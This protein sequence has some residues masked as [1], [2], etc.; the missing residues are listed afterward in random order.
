M[1]FFVPGSSGSRVCGVLLPALLLCLAWQP[2]LADGVSLKELEQLSERFVVRKR[3]SLPV[4][5]RGRNKIQKVTYGHKRIGFFKSK[6]W[7]LIGSKYLEISF[8]PPS[9][10]YP[11]MFKAQSSAGRSII[12]GAHKARSPVPNIFRQVKVRLQKG[13][14]AHR[15]YLLNGALPRKSL[16]QNPSSAK[17]SL[18]PEMYRR[19]HHRFTYLMVI[20]RLGEVVWLHVPMVDETLFSSYLSAK[21]VG[22]GYYGL[23]FGKHSG[24]FEIVKY[25]GQVMRDFS[26]KDAAKPFVMHHDFETM[27]SKKLYAVGNEVKDLY[28]FTKKS[29]DRG[30][31]FVTDTLIGI[32][33]LSGRYEK[34]L[35]FNNLFHPGKTPFMTG[36]PID[37]K[38]FVLWGEPKA[39]LDFLHINAV[40][41][42]PGEGV[43]VSFRNIS[44]V[45][46]V[47]YKFSKVLWTLGSDPQDRY[48]IASK[49]HRFQHQ[50]TPF[51]PS[52][53]TMV[54]FD[55]AIS[56]RQSRVVKYRLLPSA[57][58]AQLMWE[59]KPSPPLFSKD[60][61]SVYPIPGQD[62]Y[63]VYFVKPLASHEKV[64][65]IPHR[66][67]YFEVH[68][69][70][71]VVKAKL[72]I[73]FPVA[74]PGYRM[75]P[76]SS[77]SDDPAEGLA[78]KPS[79]PSARLETS[80]TEE[81]RL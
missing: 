53:S 67:I 79:S 62:L 7:K 43:L 56:T 68:S 49:A 77:L 9:Y 27:G 24:Y 37:D 3:I 5:L 13:E 55:N 61:S 63:G 21:K 75:M 80:A 73:I 74:S 54:L 76:I 39:D 69:N 71:A 15:F 42:V 44:K 41:Y 72:E 20:N 66:D 25:T 60:R 18:D 58:G 14:L 34:L 22:D 26:S 31:T 59:F 38:K 1:A 64:A 12:I 81:Q 78:E 57:S 48:R 51:M 65:S 2:A 40:D 47:D 10:R 50:H 16:H 8:I 36:D 46:M 19:N 4:E 28:S 23:M 6:N 35:D 33:L 17:A 29:S 32:D 45:G 70:T 11:T 30:K 52:K